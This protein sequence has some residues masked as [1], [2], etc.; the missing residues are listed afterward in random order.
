M[1]IESEKIIFVHIPKTGGTSITEVMC[2]ER[3]LDHNQVQSDP[4]KHHTLA[5]VYDRLAP[6]RN[7][8]NYTI[9]LVLRNPFD[10]VYSSYNW[11]RYVESDNPYQHGK[12]FTDYV[13]ELKSKSARDINRS[14]CSNLRHW[15]DVPG[16][17]DFDDLESVGDG[18]PV[19]GLVHPATGVRIHVLRFD[20]LAHDWEQFRDRIGASD[21]LVESNRHVFSESSYLHKYESEDQKQVILDI[22]DEEFM[23]LGNK[24]FTRD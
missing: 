17:V 22:F 2:G 4:S 13:Y 9:F 15:I 16:V 23:L 1:L 5:Q 24:E 19:P 10:V 7:L 3:G 21:S 12:G 14:L 8:T 20:R 18:G 6:D 11:H